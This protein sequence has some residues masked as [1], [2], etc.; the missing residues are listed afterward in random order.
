VAGAAPENQDRVVIHYVDATHARIGF[1]HGRGPMEMSE[2]LVC[3]YDNDH[4]I[5]VSLGSFFPRES[6]GRFVSRPELKPLARKFV[7]TL[8]GQ[9]VLSGAGDFSP[10]LISELA[11]G[12]A[13]KS[14]GDALPGFSG[15]LHSVRQTDPRLFGEARTLPHPVFVTGPFFGE[16]HGTL[17]LRVRFPRELVPGAEPLLAS[18][19]PGAGDLLF[20]SY[21]GKR[22]VRFHVDHWGTPSIQS[23][24]VEIEPGADHRLV[25]SLGSLYPGLDDTRYRKAPHLRRLERWLYVSL[26]DRVVF[27]RPFEFYQT[28]PDAVSF[29][30]SLPGGTACAPTFT[31]EFLAVRRL[32][33]EKIFPAGAALSER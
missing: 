10:V 12:A 23:D 6:D 31:G 1:R 8:D 26:N 30:V 28:D 24:L 16:Y 22:H 2:V 13:S 7:I 11:L 3:D 14:D 25:V 29:G 18:G 20:V 19:R 21:Q 9:T 5:G 15:K 4:A 32:P 27:S 17:E 33:P